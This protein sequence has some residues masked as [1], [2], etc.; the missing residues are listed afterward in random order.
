MANEGHIKLHAAKAAHLAWVVRIKGFLEG[1]NALF[2]TE[3]LSPRECGFGRWYFSPD[4]DIYRKIPGMAD[5]E[6]PLDKIHRVAQE[7]V[8]LKESGR[9]DEAEKHVE[10]IDALA[11]ELTLLIDAVEEKAGAKREPKY[12]VANAQAA[13]EEIDDIL[14]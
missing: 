2:D 8:G 10:Q 5:I 11:R 12:Q 3:M 13:D 9:I 6:A 1:H 4:A 14:F 7:A